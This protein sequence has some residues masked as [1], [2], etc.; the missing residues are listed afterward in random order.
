MY[1]NI[2]F[3]LILILVMVSHHFKLTFK[4]AL[5]LHL[6]IYFVEMAVC[7]I[8]VQVRVQ[9][10]EVGPLSLMWDVLLDMLCFYWLT[11]KAV[12]A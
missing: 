2:I 10:G 1:R 8:Y 12:P 7:I 6:F 11:N 5:K 9:F 4:H 3:P